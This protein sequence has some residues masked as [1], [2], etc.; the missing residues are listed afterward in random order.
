M[1]DPKTPAVAPE[2]RFT[3]VARVRHT[4]N[5]FYLDFAQLS[6]DQEG[7]AN[8]VSA[9]VMTPQHAKSLAE[10]LSGNIAK[11]EAAN[12]EIRMPSKPKKESV[13]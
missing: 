4:P 6:F 11:Y 8:L 5:E 1:A 10:A 7:M 2:P 12:G 3:N 13:Q 9:L